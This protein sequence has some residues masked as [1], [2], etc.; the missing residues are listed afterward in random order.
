M[1]YLINAETCTGLCWRRKPFDIY[2]NN[3]G[4]GECSH[5]SVA[6]LLTRF[7]HI[8]SNHVECNTND[9]K[10]C[11]C[12]W[13]PP[14][15]VCCDLHS[16]SE[17]LCFVYSTPKLPKLPQHSCI[18]NYSQGHH[19][20]ALSD[21]LNAWHEAK[22][23]TV[24]GWANLCNHGLCLIMT[25]IILKCIVNCMPHHKIR[26]VQDLKPEMTWANAEQYGLE[27]LELIE[28]HGAPLPTLFCSALLQLL[29]S[30]CVNTST[31]PAA[32]A[33]ESTMPCSTD[34]TSKRRN[35]CGACCCEGHNGKSLL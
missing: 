7:L 26:A 8:D 12:C 32:C 28:K 23:V 4:S 24:Y 35:K 3:A 6:V 20:M 27:N 15:S 31:S 18:P 5:D 2:F 22:M 34:I 16:P 11:L 33:S 30:D 9:P 14:L 1:D 29:S 17:F 21:A 19:D 10:G 13:V 25:N